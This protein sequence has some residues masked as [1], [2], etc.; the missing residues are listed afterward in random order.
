MFGVCARFGIVM[1]F[2]WA[3]MFPHCQMGVTLHRVE[4][5]GPFT[6][7]KEG[8]RARTRMLSVGEG[9]CVEVRRSSG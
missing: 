2:H 1:I 7:V 3:A 8:C 6:A 9:E 5:K 4:V